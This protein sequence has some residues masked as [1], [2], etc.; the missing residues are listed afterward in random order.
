MSKRRTIKKSLLLG[1]LGVAVL[2]TAP[3]L[4]TEYRFGTDPIS[5]WRYPINN[6]RSFQAHEKLLTGLQF[7]EDGT[8]LIT[9][10]AS[11]IR[12]KDSVWFWDVETLSERRQL[13]DNTAQ[14]YN[15]ALS[16]NGQRLAVLGTNSLVRVVDVADG[17]RTS[18][19]EPDGIAHMAILSPDGQLIAGGKP[20]RP[21]GWQLTF[22]NAQTG[23][24]Q[25]SVGPVLESIDA[26]AFSPSG[27]QLA[28]ASIDTLYL[29]DFVE[30]KLLHTVTIPLTRH[31]EKEGFEPSITSLQFSAD[32]KIVTTKEYGENAVPVDTATGKLL[33]PADAPASET[34]SEAFPDNERTDSK[35]TTFLGVTTQ[36][37]IS[38][39]DVKSSD[40]TLVQSQFLPR[41]PTASGTHGWFMEI[42]A[43]SNTFLAYYLADNRA[44]TASVFVG[45]VASGQIIQNLTIQRPGLG[46][47]FAAELS[48]NGETL[49]A[50]K[51][52][53]IELLNVRTGEE[54]HELTAKIPKRTK[55]FVS[56]SGVLKF[57]KDG[58][59][60]FTDNGHTF[61]LWNVETGE[62]LWTVD[63]PKTTEWLPTPAISD[64]NTRIVTICRRS[65]F[66]VLDAT[67]GDLLQSFPKPEELEFPRY[68]AF[69]PDG[70]TFAVG[71]HYGKVMLWALPKKFSV[72]GRD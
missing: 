52:K 35:K 32:G 13:A 2:L 61:Q 56:S 46:T 6:A 7:S 62:P 37:I 31:T 40:L 24:V 50:F 36:P 26:I 72:F 25:Q 17:D 8:F 22:W 21:Q 39:Y 10:S 64:D 66:C 45:D 51:D 70:E 20:Q 5:Y 19:P 42:S 38:I 53:K 11:R 41:L 33:Q 16:G 65:D 47:L 48:P 30:N 28:F 3:W 9:E 49:A 27:A 34:L 57:S 54:V 69:S 12:G 15:V 14:P 43:D 67:T 71:D 55:D 1:G 4:Y 60:L 68:F 58:T 18:I 63:Y 44:E 23:E 59:L 29:W